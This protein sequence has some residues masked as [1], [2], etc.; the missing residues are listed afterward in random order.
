VS[1][2]TVHSYFRTR[3]DL[4]EEVLERVDRYLRGTVSRVLA[5]NDDTLEAL[6]E[7]AYR[8]AH[9]AE[10]N[11]DIVKVWLDWS[12]GVDNEAW[13]AY[14]DMLDQMHRSVAASIRRSQKAGRLS[15]G[16]DARAAARVFIGG[17]HTIALTQFAGVS[18]K[19]MQAFIHRMVS[20]A[21][22]S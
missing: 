20:G 1:K 9:D 15:A 2:P 5:R 16:L 7:L 13:S 19:Q 11:P 14:V 17:G 6:T 21:L 12:T 8:F 3:H 18:G 10:H 4:V 22:G